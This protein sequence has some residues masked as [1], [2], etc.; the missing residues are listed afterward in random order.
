MA[1]QTLSD[2]FEVY[3]LGLY[4]LMNNVWNKG[5]LVNGVDFTQSVTFDTA[6][7]QRGV[8]FN[9]DWPDSG[10][11][12]VYS[13]PEIIAG[14]KAWD[15]NGPL[16]LSARVDEVKSLDVSFDLAIGG[17]TGGFNVAMEFWLTSKANGVGKDITTEVMVWL[18]DG[19]N[20]PAGT[21]IGHY[22]DGVYS[23]DIYLQENMGDASGNDPLTWRYIAIAI[24]AENYLAGSI[25]LHDVLVQLQRLNLLSATDYIGGVELGAE[26]FRGNG[27]LTVNAMDIGIDRFKVTEGADKLAGTAKDD[28]LWGRGGN[29]VLKGLAGIDHLDGGLGNDILTGGVGGDTLTGGDGYDFVD[30]FYSASAVSVNLTANTATG[31]EAAGDKLFSVECVVGSNLGNDT[32]IGN[33]VANSLYGLGGSDILSAG[34]GNDFLLGGLGNDRLAGGAGSDFFYFNTALNAATNRDT[35]TDYNAVAD[36]IRLENTGVGLFN[37]LAL[38]TLNAQFFKANATGT[39]TDT[40]DRI[41]YN[42]V[43]GALFYDANGSAAGGAIQFATLTSHPTITAADFVVI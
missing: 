24:D 16:T 9:W 14:Y 31:G 10:N 33:A 8:T 11:G 42:T 32:L 36:T 27:S 17:A 3:A 19:D 15:E 43:T 40:N 30:Y 38:G 5:D 12:S 1:L 35:I 25:D 23:G 7:T 21:V 41:I 34:L 6:S 18:H 4:K 39:A 22:D 37:T 2:D 29:D 28:N 13:Y 20:R 26:V